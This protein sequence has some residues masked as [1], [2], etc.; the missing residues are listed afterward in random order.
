VEDPWT[1]LLNS[2]IEIFRGIF[3]GLSADPLLFDS[4]I[5][6]DCSGSFGTSSHV[7]AKFNHQILD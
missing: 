1:G 3:M 4:D 6:L 2:M 5:L 7:K